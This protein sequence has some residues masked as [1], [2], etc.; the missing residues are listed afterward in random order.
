[1]NSLVDLLG[2]VE[3]GYPLTR[4]TDVF[5]HCFTTTLHSWL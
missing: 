5:M 3:R 1:M 4:P 2:R